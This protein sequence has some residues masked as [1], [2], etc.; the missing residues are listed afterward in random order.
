MD[1]SEIRPIQR[2]ENTHSIHSVDRQP[3]QRPPPEYQ[4]HGAP[5][6]EEKE[7]QKS[8]EDVIELS[9]DALAVC[10]AEE[11]EELEKTSAKSQDPEPQEKTPHVDL[12]I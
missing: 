9:T 3:G 4:R 11:E 6:K 2:V 5:K 7:P 12:A 10:S 8:E 1:Q